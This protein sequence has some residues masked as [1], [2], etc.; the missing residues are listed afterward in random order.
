MVKLLVCGGR[1]FN[2]VPYLCHVLDR[3]HSQTPITLIIEGE[4]RGADILAR[5]WAK[6]RGIPFIPFPAN[7]DR[8]G[9]AAGIFRNRTML[10]A[11]KPDRVLAFPGGK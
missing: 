10:R 3:L 2:D 11:G 7:W 6:L 5:E 1:D 4:Q 9:K 8:L